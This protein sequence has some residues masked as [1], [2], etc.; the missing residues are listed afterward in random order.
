M[1][2]L[3]NGTHTHTQTTQASIVSLFWRMSYFL[4][5]HFILFNWGD[6][7]ERSSHTRMH[8][9]GKVSSFLFWLGVFFPSAVERENIHMCSNKTNNSRSLANK[10]KSFLYWRHI[11]AEWET[12]DILMLLSNS[13]C[14]MN[15]KLWCDAIH[16]EIR[17]QTSFFLIFSKPVNSLIICFRPL[18]SHSICLAF[19]S[20]SF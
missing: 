18:R 15:V 9:K 17:S 12:H 8:E 7:N 20:T 14:Q 1:S 2:F 10:I 3:N 11:K 16:R 19:G 6:W 13:K 5:A 4:I